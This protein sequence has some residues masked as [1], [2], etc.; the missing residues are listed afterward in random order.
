MFATTLTPANWIANRG[1]PTRRHGDILIFE[2]LMAAR[3]P[4][5]K[6]F[7]V[8]RTTDVL[9]TEFGTVAVYA[10]TKVKDA[11]LTAASTTSAN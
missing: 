11:R 8:T 7:L 3:D 1:E 9:P 10:A 5:R 2:D 4:E 6:P